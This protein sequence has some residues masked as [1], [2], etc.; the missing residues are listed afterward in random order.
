MI[1]LLGSSGYIGSGFVRF[2]EAND[3]PFVGASR[4]DTDY[5]DRDALIALIDD[6]SPDFL[7]NAAGFT[8]K[9]NVDACELHKSECLAA[10][11][12]LPGTIRAACQLRRL[13]WGHVSSGCIYSGTRRDGSGFTEQDPPNFCFR[14]NHCSFYSGSKALG[15]ECLQGAG[16]VYIWRLRMPFN[17]HDSPRNYLSKLQRYE[18][19]LESTNSISELDE[20]IRAAWE[21]WDRRVE[22]GIYHLTNPG[23]VTTREITEMI[24]QELN[25]ERTFRFFRDEQHF[26]QVAAK[27]PRSNCVLDSSKILRTGIRLTEAHQAVLRALRTWKSRE[28]SGK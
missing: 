1:L 25:P 3:I 26:M 28:A 19:L 5:T 27:T 12:V 13:P 8:G 22:P 10:N 9:P 16:D 23:A 24:R 17:N 20:S 6:V 7:I 18:M 21:C 11:A 14:S 15:E 2:F 4:R